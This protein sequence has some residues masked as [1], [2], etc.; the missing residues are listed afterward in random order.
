MNNKNEQ[1]IQTTPKSWDNIFRREGHVFIKPH[2]FLPEFIAALPT[3]PASILDLGCGTGRH[4]ITLAEQGFHMVGFDQSNHG[5]QL[6]RAWLTEKG[7]QAGLCAQD[8]L[9]P[10]PCANASFDALLS[11]QVIHHAILANIQ[12]TV[13]E[14]YRVLKPAGLI[15]I[16][17]PLYPPNRPDIKEIEPATFVPLSG[18]ERG[19]PHHYFTEAGLR[20]VFQAFEILKIFTDS[21]HH[22]CIFARKPGSDLTSS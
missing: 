5:L 1:P 14:I 7:F 3:R 22:L 11:T 13:N 12:K 4:L 19:L 16:S 15:F 2:E 9:D 18:S 8:F 20:Q 17:M 10:L 6:A 21:T